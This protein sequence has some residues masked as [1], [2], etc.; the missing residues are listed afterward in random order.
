[1]ITILVVVNKDDII[2]RAIQ[3]IERDYNCE[4]NY[5]TTSINIDGTFPNVVLGA[6]EIIVLPDQDTIPLFSSK[7][8]TVSLNPIQILKSTDNI[9]V[10]RIRLE[11]PR[12]YLVKKSVWANNWDQLL[13]NQSEDKSKKG[14]DFDIENIEIVDA[15][16]A[17][18][19]QSEGSTILIEKVNYSGNLSFQNEKIIQKNIINSELSTTGF[20]VNVNDYLL[21]AD[22]SSSYSTDNS[23]V[24]IEE[25]SFEINNLQFDMEG[26]FNMLKEGMSYL[27][28]FKS[29]D[30]E[31]N[32]LLSLLNSLKDISK[33]ITKASGKFS[34]SGRAE[35]IIDKEMNYPLY[36]IYIDTDEGQFYLPNDSDTALGL[37]LSIRARN[38]NER[39]AYTSIDI[40][41]F[42][43]TRLNELISGTAEIE[44]KRDQLSIIYDIDA[45]ID[46]LNH[47][48]DLLDYEL[49]GGK[50]HLL[51]EGDFVISE[52][53]KKSFSDANFN[54]DWESENIDFRMDSIRIYSSVSEG[55]GNQDKIVVNFGK[56]NLGRSDVKGNI[57]VEQPLSIL[58]DQPELNLNLEVSSQLLDINE[59]IAGGADSVKAE[60]KWLENLNAAFNY[61]A[62]EIRYKGLAIQEGNLEGQL[63][64]NGVVIQNSD[65]SVHDSPIRL[66]GNLNGLSE[67]LE[68]NGTI[69]G[70]MDISG[71]KL[72]AERLESEY[73]DPQYLSNN[74]EISSYFENMDIRLIGEVG[75]LSYGDLEIQDNLLSL[76]LINDS[77]LVKDVISNSFG[78]QLNLKGSIVFIEDQT[79]AKLQTEISNVSIANSLESLPFLK[80]LS[81]PLSFIEGR[82]NSTL[83]LSSVLD[84]DYNLILKDVNAFALLETLEGSIKNFEPLKKV[85][86]LLGFTNKESVNV[87]IKKSKNWIT[88]Q[89]GWVKVEEFGFTIDDYH[90]TVKGAHSLEHALDYKIFAE[91]PADKLAKINN[92]GIIDSKLIEKLNKYKLSKKGYVGLFFDMTGTIDAPDIRL[93]EIDLISAGKTAIE[94]TVQEVKDSIT[95]IMDSVRT[96]VEETV[97][98]TIEATVQKGEEIAEDLI[99][100]T[101][102]LVKDEVISKVDSNLVGAIDSL[103]PPGILDSLPDIESVKEEIFK[104]KDIFKRKKKD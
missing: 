51:S 88:I 12:L 30:Q 81:Y 10:K 40:D 7:R 11:Q 87:P 45:K 58:H 57:I 26:Q 2:N 69:I 33:D 36:S 48:D 4:I 64:N 24:L 14:I 19:D 84:E 22:F 42:Q 35:G 82:I 28:D 96:E 97:R 66:V 32:N 3:E 13:S 89:D 91:V 34:I 70:T 27:V 53:I 77:L 54:V 29:K 60:Y 92:Q 98:D 25:G 44:Q 31:F 6:N 15:N 63:R 80:K 50:I 102:V 62:K 39:S 5:L 41:E 49:L 78:G 65:F 76:Q 37:N 68:G 100:S 8:I 90:F 72:D 47:F 83:S 46:D 59:W 99:D 71:D 95:T 93:N 85:N 67:Y 17:Y 52:S 38:E 103:L 74:E 20:D 23:S 101:V 79:S 55:L 73:L 16:A 18:D 56:T 104:I 75:I 9:K 1:M 86:D 21:K 94:Q 43:L 61:S